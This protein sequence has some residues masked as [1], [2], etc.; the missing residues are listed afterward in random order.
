MFISAFVDTDFGNEA[1]L[2]L[3]VC[4]LLSAAF[5]SAFAVVV[6]SAFILSIVDSNDFILELASSSNLAFTV[7]ST[8]SFVANIY[9]PHRI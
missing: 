1:N 4:N 6:T 9:S 3:Y 5:V 2:S 7:T 8:L